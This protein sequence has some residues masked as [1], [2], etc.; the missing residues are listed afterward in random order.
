MTQYP[1]YI[2]GVWTPGS[3]GKTF[4]SYNKATGEVVN[5]F[6][7]SS[8]ADV[9]AACASARAAFPLWSGLDAEARADYLMKAAAVMRRRQRE[10]AEAEA[11]E[12]GK[13]V[14]DTFSFDVRVS[15]WAF[16]YFANL[17][18]EIKGEVIPL[19]DINMRDFDFVTYEPYG[20][21]AII[22]LYNFP[23]HLLVR[24]SVV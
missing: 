22:A 12:T 4:R 6:C 9:A 11:A 1:L 7:V 23:I 20:V 21:A 3:E 2:N 14:F 18:K 8:E 10:M 5:E 13:P 19:G 24:K 15:I 16:E 17:A